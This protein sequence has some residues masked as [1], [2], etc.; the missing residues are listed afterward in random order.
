MR[1]KS[2]VLVVALL[3]SV[4]LVSHVPAVGR[5]SDLDN[6]VTATT[7]TV[8]GNTPEFVFTKGDWGVC[9]PLQM[10]I[11]YNTGGVTMIM[12]RVHSTRVGIYVAQN[13]ESQLEGYVGKCFES[14]A[15]ENQRRG[16]AELLVRF[17]K[18]HG[19]KNVNLVA[20][21]LDTQHAVRITTI[22]RSELL[23]C[24]A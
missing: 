23:R 21:Y 18:C 17:R 8:A 12:A 24:H 19:M 7:S 9:R 14:S 5:V 10:S 22:G 13:L 1:L 15:V 4:A 3:T 11:S 20:R 16:N 2:I 6:A